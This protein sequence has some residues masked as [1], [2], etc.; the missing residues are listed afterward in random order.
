MASKIDPEFY[1][2]RYANEDGSSAR[3]SQI[4]FRRMVKE[5]YS[6]VTN[7]E[8][9]HVY[10]HFD[11]GSKGFI[12]KEDFL[13]AFTTEVRQK[14]FSLGIEDI[15]KPL[16]TKARKF[17]VNLG[18]LFDKYDLDKN[19]RLSAEELRDA[20]GKNRLSLSP[21]DVM[22]LKEYFRNKYNSNEI[23]KEDF[24]NMMETKFDRKFD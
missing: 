2:N 10:K 19:H 21:D 16:A 18:A 1:F 22:I 23:K 12:S 14:T 5:L 15:V 17:N 7:L 11:R 4:E 8:L 24:I 20:L 9:S 3:M 13:T 6:K